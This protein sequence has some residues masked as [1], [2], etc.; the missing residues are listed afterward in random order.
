M[1]A[2]R[3]LAL[4]LATATVACSPGSNGGTPYPA[5]DS[6]VARALEGG[7]IAGAAVAIVRNGRL[8]F[9]GAYGVADLET[10]RPVTRDT[11]FNLASV[12][13]VLSAAIIL[14]LVE[15]GTLDLD[16]ALENWVVGLQGVE[17]TSGVTLRNALSMTSGLPDYAGADLERWIQTRQPFEA[18]FALDFVRD[19]SRV[20]EPGD[21][22]LYSNTGF[23]L[24]AL[25]AEAATDQPW[26]ELTEDFLRSVDLDGIGLCDFAGAAR[27]IGYE[28]EDG[29]FAPS[30]MD[31]EVG[32]RGDAGFCGTA[33]AIAMLPTKLLDGGLS[34][35]SLREMTTPTRLSNGVEV[36]YGIGA[37][38]GAL[39]GRRLWGHL[40][41]FGSYVAVLAHFPDDGTT[42][43][44]L[45][46]TRFA[47]IGAL[48]LFA[49]IAA[50]VFG[51]EADPLLD[52]PV[53]D[54]LIEA[55]S[56]LYIG[57]RERL[58]LEIIGAGSRVARRRPGDDAPPLPFAWQGDL[59]FGRADWPLDRY[60]FHQVD[61]E[62]VSFSAYYNG[63][64]EG[65]YT[66]SP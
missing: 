10:G 50:A 11:Q 62:V 22:W 1:A 12:G 57:D 58:Q 60:R 26:R 24:A 32:L 59:V 25:A 61:G 15:S 63:F 9:E 37:A 18:S 38:Q 49:E 45:V 20:F 29:E 4:F 66:R 47:E 40:G 46:N 56:G 17:S 14:R 28:V 33:G 19:T 51:A 30:V 39:F 35:E 36:D 21:Q 31:Q 43:S 41:G 42:I 2:M 13:K 53:P 3:L 65:Y 34:R 8:V 16:A 27:S 48:V 55:L 54:S 23:Y 6:A 44:V 7:P 5:V 64:L 52:R